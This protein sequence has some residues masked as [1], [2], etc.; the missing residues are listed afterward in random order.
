[1]TSKYILIAHQQN[2]RIF[3]P[4]VYEV[5]ADTHEP[6]VIAWD[7]AH[8]RKPVVPGQRQPHYFVMVSPSIFDLGEHVE[9]V[10]GLDRLPWNVLFNAMFGSGFMR[11]TQEELVCEN[12][13]F[14]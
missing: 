3:H 2:G 4:Y 9:K 11:L 12:G 7:H 8:K 13:S 1:M 6:V 10:I 5:D 14:N